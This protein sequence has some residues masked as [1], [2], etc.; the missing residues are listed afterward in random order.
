MAKPRTK[1][2][3]SPVKATRQEGDRLDVSEAP[4]AVV[5]DENDD[6]YTSEQVA[7]QALSLS[8]YLAEL[9]ILRNHVTEGDTGMHHPSSFICS[10]LTNACQSIRG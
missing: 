8:A 4:A 2:L 5:Q 9:G 6:R 1:A 3:H 7:A 10:Q